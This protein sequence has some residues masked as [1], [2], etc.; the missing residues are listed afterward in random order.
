MIERL[1]IWLIL[2]LAVFPFHLSG[3][4]SLVVNTQDTVQSLRRIDLNAPLIVPVENTDLPAGIKNYKPDPVRA[5]WLGAVIPGY[6][7]ILNRKFWKLPIV[8]GGF[9][10]CFYAI[11]WNS[12]R[13]I[14]YK[15]AYL[16][17]ID[18]DNQTNSFLEIIPP[19]YTIDSY[20]GEAAFTNLLKSGMDKSRYNRDLSIIV[21]IAY[22]G[23]TLIDAFVDA[24]LYDF[25]I[26]PDLSLKL[27]PSIINERFTMNQLSK[28]SFSYGFSGSIK[29]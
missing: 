6:G 11:N 21:T 13:F 1:T 17:I 20:G 24:H 5:I 15:N 4:D 25:D 8:Y 29:F 12:G 16:D 19:G 10:G 28:S 9:L 26:S 27:R 3:Q 7:Q 14:S 22:Y 2:L 18:G 23:L